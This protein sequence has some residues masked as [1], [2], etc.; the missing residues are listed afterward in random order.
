MLHRRLD[1]VLSA[2]SLVSVLEKR[3]RIH[4]KARYTLDK[5]VL[6]SKSL[7]CTLQIKKD[8][9][10]QMNWTSQS[11]VMTDDFRPSEQHLWL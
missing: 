7:H 11:E 4:K 2:L 5:N 1:N 3:T 9:Y 10:L 6:V 8:L